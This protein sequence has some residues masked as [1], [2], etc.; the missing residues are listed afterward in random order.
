[1]DQQLIQNALSYGRRFVRYGKPAS[2]IPELASKDPSKL[3][4]AVCDMEEIQR[5]NLP[6][7]ASPS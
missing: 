3:G 2:Y 7:R 5:K 4:V 6:C 1:M